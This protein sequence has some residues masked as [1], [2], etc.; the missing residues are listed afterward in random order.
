ME[1]DI[2]YELQHLPKALSDLYSISFDQIFQLGH[3]S[4]R[5]ALASLQLL[6]VAVRPIP[7]REF[8]SLLSRSKSVLGRTTTKAEIL[9]ITANLMEDDKI[10]DLPRFVH[11][12]A[13]EYL[14]TRP[15]FLPEVANM[16]A[17]TI[18]LENIA[19]PA[20]LATER[21]TYSTL[22]IGNHLSSTTA[23]SRRGAVDVITSFLVSEP[24]NDASNSGPPALFNTWRQ[25][26][27]KFHDTQVF[28]AGPDQGDAC[29]VTLVSSN[30]LL[31][32]CAMG[33]DEVLPALRHISIESKVD[34]FFPSLSWK[35]QEAVSRYRNRNCLELAVM[36]QRVGVLHQLQIMGFGNAFSTY[37]NYEGDSLLHLA[38]KLG[39]AEVLEALL[40]L[41]MNPN[42]QNWAAQTKQ[43]SH[44]ENIL[45]G[46]STD[47]I[48]IRPQTSMG[49]RTYYGGKSGV[50]SPFHANSEAKYPI[51]LAAERES[52]VACVEVLIRYGADVNIRTSDQTT[53]LQLALESRRSKHQMFSILLKAGARPNDT[54]DKGQ[55]ILHLVAAMGLSN[56][57]EL[58]LAHGADKTVVDDFGHTPADMALRYG[59]A[60]TAKMLGHYGPGSCHL[61]LPSGTGD[62]A[63]RLRPPNPMRERR[64]RST[65]DLPIA[66]VIH[67]P[68][69]TPL[70][71]NPS[72]SNQGKSRRGISPKASFSALVK[73]EWSRMKSNFR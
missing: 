33:L 24:G 55:T 39:Y 42:K 11:L 3:S 5:L 7:W 70:G 29:Q 57:V 37:A 30:P 35:A 53:T 63:G 59:H 66:I 60:E 4:Y 22:Y 20:Y 27:Q 46:W 73:Q 54:L 6:V 9:D 12:S 47:P 13:R 51:H 15:E 56:I 49:Y 72:T 69:A 68:E 43:P 36:F 44:S 31:A 48:P 8:L 45:E 23:V 10:G 16:A 32:I 34:V 14:E 38:A 41:G 71:G 64:V 26:I 40:Q 18:C 58:L 65:G 21:Y 61:Q 52:G 50:F 28:V 19:H 17:A 67:E 1:E 25:K 62:D 2:L